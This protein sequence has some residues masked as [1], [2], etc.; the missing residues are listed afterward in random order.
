MP[1]EDGG[2]RDDT[3]KIKKIRRMP[4]TFENLSTKTKHLKRAAYP[5]IL[6][7]SSEPVK[8]NLTQE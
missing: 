2:E 8:T 5:T 3:S 7:A 1:W 4:P 6:S